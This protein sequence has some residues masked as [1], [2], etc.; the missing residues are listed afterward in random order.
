MQIENK[1][2]KPLAALG[3]D[4]RQWSDAFEPDHLDDWDEA[5]S[6]WFDMRENGRSVGAL[7][8]VYV[9]GRGWSLERRRAFGEPGW[10]SVAD[11]ARMDRWVQD[12]ALQTVPEGSLLGGADAAREVARFLRDP[13]VLPGAPR[14]MESRALNWPERV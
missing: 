13:Q 6:G 3:T 4:P 14:W 5:G 7:F 10:V 1:W 9:Q 8:V 11:P 12:D 2:D